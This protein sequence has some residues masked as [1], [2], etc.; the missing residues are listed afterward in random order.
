MHRDA[1]SYLRLAPNLL[2]G[3]R[4]LLIPLLSIAALAG[5]GQVAGLGLLL[6]GATD[7]LDGRLARRLDVASPRGAQIDAIADGLLL[8]A[9]SAW[10]AWLHPE[11]VSV[12]SPIT[13]CALLAWTVSTAATAARFRELRNLGGLSAKVAGGCLYGFA[14][15]T[16][17][18]GAYEPLLL[19]IAAGAL[20]VSSTETLIINTIDAIASARKTRSHRPHAEKPVGTSSTAITSSP[21]IARPIPRQ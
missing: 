3:I 12:A 4:L 17:L 16:L 14:V 21:I 9:A 20:I 8:V 1:A 6:A 10:L 18:S 11:I 13:V 19:T 15:F 7:F 5:E 2:T